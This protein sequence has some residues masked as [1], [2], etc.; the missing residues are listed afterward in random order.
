M[1]IKMAPITQTG[2]KKYGLT[3][4]V[5]KIA[6]N[7]TKLP[8]MPSNMVSGSASSTVLWTEKMNEF[9]HFKYETK[10]SIDFKTHPISFEKRFK[11]LPDG[12]VSKNRI[13]VKIIPLNIWL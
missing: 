9:C 10:S 7:N 4:A 8:C 1:K 5:T 3:V 12:F 13:V 11:I 6:P 2:I